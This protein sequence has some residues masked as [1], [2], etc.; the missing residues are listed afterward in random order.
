ASD[1]NGDGYSDY[2]L[3]YVKSNNDK[4]LVKMLLVDGKSLYDNMLTRS[5]DVTMTYINGSESSILATG[6]SVAGGASGVT[7]ANSIRMTK[8]DFDGDGRDEI[9][10]YYTLIHGAGINESRA[11]QLEI[12]RVNYDTEKGY[13]GKCVYNTQNMADGSSLLQHNSVGLAAGDINADGKDELVYIHTDSPNVTTDKYANVYMSICS[14]NGDVL[15]RHVD[16]SFQGTTNFPITDTTAWSSVPP[17]EAKIADFDG[18]GFGELVWSTGTGSGGVELKLWVH[19]WDITQGGAIANT[20]NKYEYNAAAIGWTLNVLYKHH[21]LTTGLFKY[22]TNGSLVRHQIA[23]AH[24]GNGDNG[25]ANMDVAILS[26]SKDKG[27]TGEGSFNYNN[28]QMDGNMGAS[29][30]AVDLYGESLV[31]G[32]PSVLTVEENIELSMVTQAPPKHWDK[33]SAASSDLFP[34]ADASG[35]LTIDAF[36]VF[37]TKDYYTAMEF[38]QTFGYSSSTTNVSEGSIGVDASYALEHRENL[39]EKVFANNTSDDE[40]LLDIGI[41]YSRNEV[42]KHTDNYSSTM[43]FEVNFKADRDDQ[44]YYHTNNYNICRY[45]ILLPKSKRYSTT[46]DDTTG[47]VVSL[48]NYVQYVVPTTVNPTFAPTP[49]RNISW[50]E[51]LH[52]NYNLFT[53]PKRLSDIS[54]YPQGKEAKLEA[55][56]YD[57]WADINGKVF[58]SGQNNLIGN[59]D[60]ND[61][62]FKS[63]VSGSM[64]DYNSIRQTLGGHV[65]FHPTF[66]FANRQH[67]NIDLTGDYS[68]GTDSTTTTDASKMLNVTMAWPGAGAYTK[69]TEDW[70]AKDMQFYVDVAYFTQDDGAI[71]VGYA[72]PHL[73]DAESKIWGP[74][75]PYATHP[76]PGLLLPFRWSN[77][78]KN[79]GVFLGEI[80]SMI[81]YLIENEDKYSSN[82]M[83]GITFTKSDST[84]N[85]A[86]GTTEDGLSPKLLEKEKA[87]NVKLR[88]INYSFVQAEDVTVK[89]YFQPWSNESGA[90]NYPSTDPA[91]DGY[92][93]FDSAKL[94]VIRERT[95]ATDGFDNWTNAEATFKAPKTEGLGWVHAVLEYND[96]E[97]NTK[98]NHGWVLVGSYDPELFHGAAAS[99]T[100]SA[101][102]AA[103]Q[104]SLPAAE[105]PNIKVKEVKVYEIKRDAS[106]NISY[107]E[108]KLDEKARYKQLRVDA[109]VG[110]IGGKIIRGGKE[111][112]ISCVPALRCALFAGKGKDATAILGGSQRPVMKQ[113]QDYTF[114]FVYDPSQCPPDSGVSVRAF[115]PYLS[116]S[117][118][119]DLTSQSEELWRPLDSSSGSGC[120]A[121][122][123]VLSLLA[124]LPLMLKKKR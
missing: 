72:V 100:V 61:C 49:G 73:K 90:R 6:S 116:R 40:P 70:T 10:L 26:W 29:V 46:S 55:D 78:I 36:A 104:A 123:A 88:V 83:R 42:H 23:L 62:Q 17:I 32:S 34:L 11:N 18:D 85:A 16:R 81:Y 114:S 54:G 101:S 75:S 15:V 14:L 80:E 69:Y 112:Q 30:A 99:N 122:F 65:Y 31:L 4:P 37:E 59:T 117:E 106:G 1:W 87:Y 45:P 28:V 68:W 67:L 51:P 19:D 22:P 89:F 74:S 110:F 91:R 63:S 105:R 96:Q 57:P 77:D 119:G 8:G 95:T 76:D 47:T 39:M 5:G 44:L 103:A 98:N 9:A 38:E 56:K 52:D 108:T 120:N 13:Q 111:R 107:E 7:P 48:Q 66:G 124:L 64:E 92:T 27:L 94:P 2:I 93:P 43:G 82:Q 118:Q 97:L 86:T 121:G 113:G 109:T 50:Y 71:C 79:K 53:Y 115:S 60:N 12:Y 58:I 84:E 20:G 25:M 35:D 41:K 102:S 21:S 33:V 3:T 24:M